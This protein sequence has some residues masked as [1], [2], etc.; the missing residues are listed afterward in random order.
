MTVLGDITERGSEA[1]GND[2]ARAQQKRDR[3]RGIC[4]WSAAIFFQLL[5][6]VAMTYWYSLHYLW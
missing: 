3:R 1:F 5:T 2:A 4:L 6:A